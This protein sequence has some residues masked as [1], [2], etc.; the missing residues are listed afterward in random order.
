MPSDTDDLT[1]WLDASAPPLHEPDGLSAA[2]GDVVLATRRAGRTGI[3]GPRRAL[4]AGT[5]AVALIV[6][7]T[8]AAASLLEW[9]A[10]WAQE[11]F[12]SITYTLP[13]G[14]TCE[15]RTGG[16]HVR[17]PGARAEVVAWLEENSLSE[18]VDVDGAIARL[19]AERSTAAGIGPVGYGT[20]HY[21]ADWEYHTAVQ[22]ALNAAIAA[23]L[24]QEGAPV[25]F[26]W[27]S[28]TRCTGDN[29]DPGTPWWYE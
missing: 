18:I 14:G 20:D 10:P 8:A 3:L 27:E 12:G 1:R 7:G 17:D 4:A 28:E 22:D 24:E 13:S 15:Q 26:R 21:D 11:P 19:R 9:T 5:G 2:V 23:R 25:S 16:L 29:P 6:G